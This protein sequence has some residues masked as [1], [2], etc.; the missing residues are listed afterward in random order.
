[1]ELWANEDRE[2]AIKRFNSCGIAVKIA[3]SAKIWIDLSNVQIL[4]ENKFGF[5]SNLKRIV[6]RFIKFLI[7]HSNQSYGMIY[8]L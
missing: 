7:K 6:G 5:K 8:N 3:S 1:M 4:W 2:S